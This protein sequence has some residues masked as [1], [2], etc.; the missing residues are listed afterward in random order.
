MTLAEELFGKRHRDLS[1]DERREYVRASKRRW[2]EANPQREV[3]NVMRYQARNPE[4]VREWQRRYRQRN[5]ERE[6][7]RQRRWAEANPDR[8]QAIVRRSYERHAAERNAEN[9][10]WREQNPDKERE[11]K[12]RYLREHPEVFRA[13]AARRRARA[14]DAF[15]EDVQPDEVLRRSD[16]ACGICGQLIDPADFHVDHIVPLAKGGEHSYVNC[17]VAHP[18]C[19]ARKGAR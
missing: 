9:R 4:K 12:Q 14:H 10:L 16:G 5:P 18:S 19:N 11:R 3:A 8:R 6:A 7:D 1:A 13:K 17:Q 2:R 15:V